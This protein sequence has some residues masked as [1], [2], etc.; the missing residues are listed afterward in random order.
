MKCCVAVFVLLMSL[1]Q[2]LAEPSAL[3]TD[4]TATVQ[5]V[6]VV[7]HLKKG[8]RSKCLLGQMNVEGQQIWAR[9]VVPLNQDWRQVEI[10]CADHSIIRSRLCLRGRVVNV[11]SQS[12]AFRSFQDVEVGDAFVYVRPDLASGLSSV[13]IEIGLACVVPQEEV[14]AS[15]VD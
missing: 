9:R 11:V 10:E 2:A 1:A 15:E 8:E 6:P 5:T 12:L 7:R 13:E 3:R 4:A 14:C